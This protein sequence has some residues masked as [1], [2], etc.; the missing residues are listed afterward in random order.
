MTSFTQ[1]LPL[2]QGIDNQICF[3]IIDYLINNNVWTKKVFGSAQYAYNKDDLASKQRPSVMCLPLWSN[4]NSFAY[5]QDGEVVLQLRFSLQQQRIDLAQNVIQIANLIQLINL[6]Q[7]F[8]QYAQTLMPGLFWI[9]KKC[10][11]N[12]SRVYAKESLVEI[13]LD[14]K[15]DLLAYQ[16]ELQLKGYDITSPDEKIYIAVQNLLLQNQILNDE[17]EVVITV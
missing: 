12:Y 14:Y 15:V 6:N 13:T 8:S 5:S 10:N 3:A 17:Q 2:V 11:A 9:G 16:K 7:Q 4:K 1:A